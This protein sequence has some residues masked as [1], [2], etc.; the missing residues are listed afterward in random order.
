MEK[1]KPLLQKKNTSLADIDTGAYRTDNPGLKEIRGTG[2]SNS[3]IEEKTVK[4]KDKSDTFEGKESSVLKGDTKDRGLATIDSPKGVSME[5][6]EG[7][8][9]AKWG[10]YKEPEYPENAQNNGWSGKVGLLIKF[11][12]SGNPKSIIVEEKS[13]YYELDE[14]A[15][16]AAKSWKIY[17]T[18]NGTPVSGTVRIGIRFRLK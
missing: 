3:S 17:I 10:R 5:V 16:R 18:D 13:G 9:E 11:D 15:K 6:T 4:L 2:E 14:S 8:G 12:P 7:K 1:E